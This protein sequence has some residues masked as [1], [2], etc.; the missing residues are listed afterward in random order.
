MYAINQFCQNVRVY[1]T[2]TSPWLGS[3]QH[4]PDLNKAFQ[5][6][7]IGYIGKYKRDSGARGCSGIPAAE[8]RVRDH[9]HTDSIH[10]TSSFQGTLVNWHYP[11]TILSTLVGGLFK[12]PYVKL[13]DIWGR[14]QA[15]ALMIVCMTVGLI[16]MAGC[17]NVQTYCA[18]QVSY[19]VGSTGVDFVMTIFIADTSALTNR[20]FWLAFTGSPYIATVWAYGQ[21]RKTS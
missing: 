19:S 7:V 1:N 20:A 6:K 9:R 2:L 4:K 5:L 16:M 18:A 17:N 13:I 11:T 3:P 14:P 12:L 10:F 21:R 8:F 15:F